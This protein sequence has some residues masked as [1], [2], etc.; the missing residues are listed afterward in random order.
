MDGG[1]VLRAFLAHRWGYARGTQIAASVGQAAAFL[2]GLLGLLGGSPLLVF[3]ALF[4]ISLRPRRRTRR[5]C[6]RFR[7][8]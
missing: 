2:F 6:A 3:I 8:A 1:R 7:G 5:K 4:V